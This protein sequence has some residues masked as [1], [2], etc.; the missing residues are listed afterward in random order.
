[1]A[2]D[3]FAQKPC[4][5]TCS[6]SALVQ[7]AIEHYEN[8]DDLKRVLVKPEFLVQVLP[9]PELRDL[10]GVPAAHQ[11]AVESASGRSGRARV[12]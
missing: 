2:N 4:I 9:H 10:H 12:P 5:G 1:M 6:I 8:L 3:M 11:H 7:R